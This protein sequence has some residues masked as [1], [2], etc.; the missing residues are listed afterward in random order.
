MLSKVP[1][2]HTIV[3]L[4]VRIF[5]I[6]AH[7]AAEEVLIEKLAF[8]HLF[9]DITSLLEGGNWAHNKEEVVE[10]FILQLIL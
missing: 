6:L 5:L 1:D 8:I 4:N 2:Y 3:G 10:R 7:C 9:S